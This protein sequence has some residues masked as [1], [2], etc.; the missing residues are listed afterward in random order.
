[1]KVKLPQA[2][3][4]QIQTSVMH[5]LRIKGWYCFRMNS[6]KY[7]V[8]E[9]RQRRFIQ[10][11]EAGTPDLMAFKNSRYGLNV[12][13]VYPLPYTGISLLFLEIKKPGNKPT[14]LQTAKM[15]ELQAYGATCYVIHSLQELQDLGI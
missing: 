12:E 14:L 1:M 5:Y 4:H 6:G 8:G 7:S 11:H 3:E 15:K 13:D 2:S 10:G 9:G